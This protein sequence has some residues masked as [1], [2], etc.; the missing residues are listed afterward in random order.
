MALMASRW[1]GC[2]SPREG[3]LDLKRAI[4]RKDFFFF[5]WRT[6]GLMGLVTVSSFFFFTVGVSVF[7]FFFGLRLGK[8]L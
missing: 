4:F 2:P 7:V 8:I 1:D 6:S 5:F 3:T